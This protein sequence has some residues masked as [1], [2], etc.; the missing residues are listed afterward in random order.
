VNI[1]KLKFVSKQRKTLSWNSLSS[2]GFT[3]I[4]KLE[5]ASKTKENFELKLVVVSWF[6]QHR[7]IGIFIRKQRKTLS[8]TSLS[9]IG[10][11]NIA[12]LEFL[13][14]NKEKL[15]AEP[16]R[17]LLA[18]STSQDW[19]LIRKQRKTLSWNPLSWVGFINIARLE[20]NSKTKKNSEL[21]PVVVSW[22]YQ[23]RKIGI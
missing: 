19:N 10:F 14:E 22:L 20:F 7:K 23:H 3:N 18:L 13:F 5:F 17:C 21:K 9:S 2:V 1:A 12:K 8:W 4:A 6:Y 16:R 11:V 15:W